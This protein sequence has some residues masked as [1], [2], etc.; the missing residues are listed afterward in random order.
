MPRNVKAEYEKYK[1][2]NLQYQKDTLRQFKFSLNKN[3]ELPLIEWLE[4]QPNKQNYLRGLIY[5]DMLRQME[6]ESEI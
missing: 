5:Q 3:T 1:E 4:K 2:W 6:A